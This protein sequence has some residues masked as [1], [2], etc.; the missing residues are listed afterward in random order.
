MIDFTS[1]VPVAFGLSFDVE[2]APHMASGYVPAD[3]DAGSRKPLFGMLRLH[4]FIS[5]LQLGF[6]KKLILVGGDEARYKH[7][8]PHVN[9]AVSIRDML[10][11]DYGIEPDRVE[12][13]PSNSNTGGNLDIIKGIVERHGL[14]SDDYIVTSNHYHLP[15]IVMDLLTK[16]LAPNVLPAEAFWLLEAGRKDDLLRHLQGDRLAE[17]VAEEIQGAADK[18]RGVY[19]P[20]MDLVAVGTETARAG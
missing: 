5:L 18:M 1:G 19:K 20:R 7:E 12:A 2:R 4:G 15:R 3:V 8:T 10:V 13:F 14:S 9:R 16:G 6:A 17:R 11:T